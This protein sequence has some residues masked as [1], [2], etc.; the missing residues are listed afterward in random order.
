M[1]TPVAVVAPLTLSTVK[2]RYPRLFRE[3]TALSDRESEA[4]DDL[5]LGTRSRRPKDKVTGLYTTINYR[6]FTEKLQANPV[7]I[8]FKTESEGNKYFHFV[9]RMLSASE[10]GSCGGDAARLLQILEAALEGALLHS[11]SAPEYTFCSEQCERELGN[12]DDDSDKPKL[13]L[14]DL[15]YLAKRRRPKG[16][17][18]RSLPATYVATTT[19]VRK[20]EDGLSAVRYTPSRKLMMGR[21]TIPSAAFAPV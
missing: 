1:V 20:H 15:Y 2:N 7:D 6:N 3:Y 17:D 10:T 19:Y 4:C 8:P 13:K 14:I 18:I 5:D 11:K 16:R 12:R 9:H 21:I